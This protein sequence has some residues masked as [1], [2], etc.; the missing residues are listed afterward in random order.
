MTTR[1]VPINIGQ[2]QIDVSNKLGVENINKAFSETITIFVDVRDLINKFSYQK[3][4]GL[5]FKLADFEAKKEI[6]ELAIDEFQDKITPQE[7]EQIVNG[8]NQA[9]GKVI[10]KEKVLQI[11]RQGT[12]LVPK[13]A[14]II[15]EVLELAAE[16]KDYAEKDLFPLFKKE[17]A[18]PI[19]A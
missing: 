18:L 14:R 17:E 3:A 15:K 11:V 16:T 1:I 2:L 4:L 12:L 10:E 6:F 13:W 5:L 9:L 8:V 19:A 7:I